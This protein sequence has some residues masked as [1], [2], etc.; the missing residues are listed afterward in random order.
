MKVEVA[1]HVSGAISIF[2]AGAHGLLDAIVTADGEGIDT[3]CVGEH[4]GLVAAG[5]AAY[6]FGT[7][8]QSLDTPFL[9][10]MQLFS[11]M[12]VQTSRIRFCAGVMVAPLRSGVLLAKNLATLDVLSRGRADAGL[13]A[14]WHR[15]EFRAS[16]ADF[17]RRVDTLFEQI[18][19]CRLLWREGSAT[20]S[21]DAGTFNGLHSYPKPPQGRDLP[22]WIGLRPTV[23]LAPRIVSVANGWVAAPCTPDELRRSVSSLHRACVDIGR[24]P[25]SLQVRAVLAAPSKATC[26]CEMT[27]GVDGVADLIASGATSIAVPMASFVS[28]EACV[29]ELI[30]MCAQM[31]V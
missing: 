2:S 12:A 29:G 26:V 7:Y 22:I 16:N 10:P 31:R 20:Y 21:S 18:E 25:A 13:G 28:H 5:L 24:D 15:E 1:L 6:P 27:S 11:A 23:R 14:G 17:E 4:V 19:I 9:D 30:A 8:P 3:V